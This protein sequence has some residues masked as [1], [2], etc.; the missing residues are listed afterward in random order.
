MGVNWVYQ[1]AK[2][3]SR[4]A[5]SH[6]HDHFSC[7]KIMYNPE[8]I[9]QAHKTHLTHKHLRNKHSVVNK[10]KALRGAQSSMWESKEFYIPQIFVN[11]IFLTAPLTACLYKLRLWALQQ[12]ELIGSMLS[13]ETDKMRNS[14][15]AG[16]FFNVSNVSNFNKKFNNLWASVIMY[17]RAFYKLYPVTYVKCSLIIFR[18]WLWLFHLSPFFWLHLNVCIFAFCHEVP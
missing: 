8:P 14:K 3:L 16:L 12:I 17:K 11:R 9:H 13:T 2:S 5:R 1:R 7:G 15:G 4:H 6:I 10:L 18:I